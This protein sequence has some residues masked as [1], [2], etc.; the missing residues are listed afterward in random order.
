MFAKRTKC[1]SVRNDYIPTNSAS[2]CCKK[3]TTL[4]F[5]V[6]NEQR[7]PLVL[8][9]N[10]AFRIVT[11][12]YL[13][14]DHTIDFC[15]VKVFMVLLETTIK[16]IKLTKRPWVRNDYIPNEQ[17]F[18]FLLETN[19]VS[20]CC[21]K[22]TTL[23]ESSWCCRKQRALYWQKFLNPIAYLQS[24]ILIFLV[25][26]FSADITKISGNMTQVS[27]DMTRGEMTLGRLD[28]LPFSWVMRERNEVTVNKMW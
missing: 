24:E 28:R 20:F 9:T 10:N 11:Q 1:P 26:V 3:R 5:G 18:I 4:P 19:N 23:L 27:G 7:F 25:F 22:W 15:V 2:F 8:Q 16:F 6:T 17:R 21:K 14:S 12:T 13:S